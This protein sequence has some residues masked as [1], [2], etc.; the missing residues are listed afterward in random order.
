MKYKEL[1]FSTPREAVESAKMDI[2]NDLI[3]Y[4]DADGFAV[5][6]TD[7]PYES[8]SEM[9]GA[10][11]LDDNI[12]IGSTF[13]KVLYCNVY[14]Y[15][16]V[17]FTSFLMKDKNGK[18]FIIQLQCDPEGN[19]DGFARIIDHNHDGDSIAIKQIVERFGDK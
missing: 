3:V 14:G 18:H 2:N 9:I 15:D 8:H 5:G 19:R 10:C 12:L 1:G 16:P 11:E 17:T 4:S 13:I 7:N 6:Y